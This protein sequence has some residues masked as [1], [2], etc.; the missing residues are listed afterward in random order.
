M[1]RYSD[2]SDAMLAA[3][4]CTGPLEVCTTWPTV[5]LLL[6][7]SAM[8]CSRRGASKLICSKAAAAAAQLAKRNEAVVLMVVKGTWV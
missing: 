6:D 5:Q 7:P 4:P 2:T 8:G 3:W 1:P